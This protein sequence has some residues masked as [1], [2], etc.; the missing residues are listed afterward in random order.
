LGAA[1]APGAH[2]TVPYHDE[3]TDLVISE[4]L[5]ASVRRGAEVTATVEADTSAALP[6]AE[7]Q[8]MG[9]IVFAA[10]GVEIGRRELVTEDGFPEAGWSTRL[11]YR[12][13]GAWDWVTSIF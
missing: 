7:G 10:D 2:V 4:P 3:G 13:H 9:T 12:A 1:G 8:A 11:R 6:L 5:T